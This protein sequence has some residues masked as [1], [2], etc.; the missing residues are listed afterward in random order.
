[1]TYTINGATFKSKNS[2]FNHVETVFQPGFYW[3]KGKDLDVF[4]EILE[5]GF[6]GHDKGKEITVLWINFKKSESLL[7]IR[8][9]KDVIDCLEVTTNVN[10]KGY[11]YGLTENP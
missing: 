2:F 4:N 10:F 3:K 8:F 5:G 1:M 9:T 6:G 11:D 7:G